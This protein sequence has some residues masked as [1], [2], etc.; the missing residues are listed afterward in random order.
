MNPPFVAR[1]A[2]ASPDASEGQCGV[3][4]RE[5]VELGH[6]QVANKGRISWTAGYRVFATSQRRMRSALWVAVAP[7]TL[8]E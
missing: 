8:V 6:W 4:G 7:S 1:R 2:H 3:A 5:Q